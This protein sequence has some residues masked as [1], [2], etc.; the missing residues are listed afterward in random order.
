MELLTG[1]A[2]SSVDF[3][4]RVGTSGVAEPQLLEI[5]RQLHAGLTEFENR[6]LVHRDLKPG[7][8]MVERSADDAGF[9][10]VLID[11]GLV[12]A[13][14]HTI[15]S[16]GA[17][18]T[19]NYAAPEAWFNRTSRAYD[20][21]S[22]GLVVAELAQG[23]HPFANEGTEV[24][25]GFLSANPDLSGI[26]DLRW[27]LL[28]RGLMTPD[29]RN[30]WRSAEVAE[31]LDGG[32]PPVIVPELHAF[33]FGDGATETAEPELRVVREIEHIER[34]EYRDRET[35]ASGPGPAFQT[36]PV[37]PLIFLGR[38]YRRDPRR[39]A[40]A[41][42]SHW[43]DA[44]R[45]LG[46]TAAR[47]ELAR[48]VGQFHD[49]HLLAVV[50]DAGSGERSLDQ[51]LIRVIGA[52]Y[53]T[54]RGAND[55]IGAR[56]YH[57]VQLHDHAV[58]HIVG[59]GLALAE[60][61]PPV[62]PGDDAGEANTQ[63]DRSPEL[64]RALQLVNGDLQEIADHCGHG[65]S[66]Q[67]LARNFAAAQR[68]VDLGTRGFIDDP[69]EEWELDLWRLQLAHSLSEAGAAVALRRTARRAT[70]LRPDLQ[71]L[72]GQGT[73]VAHHLLATILARR[74]AAPDPWW[75]RTVLLVSGVFRGQR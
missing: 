11:F 49:P 60:E 28:I 56:W 71:D 62:L 75:R 13:P 44:A 26:E 20:W 15:T 53:R 70:R 23:R 58:H 29:P 33:G 10:C 72:S 67:V 9:R 22:L 7:N 48:W 24:E 37:A 41:F 59:A 35:G 66:T 27:R 38:E 69:R 50:D 40:D 12:H 25:L 6:G 34:I 52:L 19:P 5:V 3:L 2:L 4:A 1:Q 74:T 21:F 17:N 30:R 54:R 65:T 43:A 8:V 73:G 39:L 68:F 57:D 47:Q 45:L 51:D 42:G 31:W 64:I 18:Y 63:P 32:T 14:T 16:F 46:S 55:G 61:L 36:P